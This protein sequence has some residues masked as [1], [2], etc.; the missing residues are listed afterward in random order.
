MKEGISLKRKYP[1]VTPDSLRRFLHTNKAFYDLHVKKNMGYTDT[2]GSVYNGTVNNFG[3]E[4]LLESRKLL[5]N[6]PNIDKIN[7]SSKFQYYF[8]IKYAGDVSTYEQQNMMICTL[9]ENVFINNHTWQLKFSWQSRPI[10]ELGDTINIGIVHALSKSD[11]IIVK[12]KFYQTTEDVILIKDGV[13]IQLPFSQNGNNTYFIHASNAGKEYVEL[14]PDPNN[15]ANCIGCITAELTNEEW[16]NQPMFYICNDALNTVTYA[17]I[18]ATAYDGFPLLRY[19]ANGHDNSF[20]FPGMEPG[21]NSSIGNLPEELNGNWFIELIPAPGYSFIIPSNASDRQNDYCVIS[22]V[23]YYQAATYDGTPNASYEYTLPSE[24]VHHFPNNNIVGYMHEGKMYTTHSYSTEIKPDNSHIYLDLEEDKYYTWNGSIYKENFFGGIQYYVDG[25]EVVHAYAAFDNYKNNYGPDENNKWTVTGLMRIEY[26]TIKMYNYEHL[27]VNAVSGIHINSTSMHSDNGIIQKNG[28]THNMSEFDGLPSYFSNFY[29]NRN[30]CISRSIIYSIRDDLN[31]ENQ[32]V[33]DKPTAALIVDSGYPITQVKYI[34][35]MES[36]I[37][38]ADPYTYEGDGEYESTTNYLSDIAYVTDQEFADVN[39]TGEN[40]KYRFVYHGDYFFSTDVIEFDPSMNYGRVYYI[41]NDPSEFR[42]NSDGH[43]PGRT[44]ARICDIPTSFT[45]LSHITNYAPTY[46]VDVLYNRTQASYTTND[47][48]KVWNEY[49]PKW[50]CH[51]DGVIFPRMY[52]A[53]EMSRDHLY[54]GNMHHIYENPDPYITIP[55][56]T[57]EVNVNNG[58]SGYSVGDTF[59]FQVGGQTVTGTVETVNSGQAL[60]ISIDGTYDI[61]CSFLSNLTTFNASTIGGT[62]TGLTVDVV[63]PDY[64]SFVRY[65]GGY[66]EDMCALKFDVIDNIWIYKVTQSSLD[67]EYKLTGVNCPDNPYVGYN[68][69]F[70]EL[71]DAFVDDILKKDMFVPDQYL[72]KYRDDTMLIPVSSS[73]VSISPEILPLDIPIDTDED[74]SSYLTQINQ[75]EQNT[76]FFIYKRTYE[77]YYRAEKFTAYPNPK[78]NN[79]VLPKNHQLNLPTYANISCAFSYIGKDKTQLNMC[80]FNPWKNTISDY[81]NIGAN[82]YNEKT[83]RN[84]PSVIVDS[85]QSSIISEL[86]H[87]SAYVSNGNIYM[88]GNGDYTGWIETLESE[89]ESMTREELLQ[90]IEDKFNNPHAEPLEVE[91]HYDPSNPSFRYTKNDLITYILENSVDDINKI[92][93]VHLIETI[94]T[95]MKSEEYHAT[96]DYQILD[97]IIVDPDA[98]VGEFEHQENKICYVFKFDTLISHFSE[99][100]MLDADG[101]DISDKC[102]IIYDG[103]LWYWNGSTWKNPEREVI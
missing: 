75:N 33:M 15:N 57:R 59:A 6:K 90:Y 68:V 76:M 45:Q 36:D 81:A 71:E 50:I 98:K 64:N 24:Y 74:L 28:V 66:P 82:E 21:T 16:K 1:I 103:Y 96:G 80:I 65:V 67:K 9:K 88:S 56:P 44:L 101:N 69:E 42:S 37:H 48:F 102:L 58:G 34:Y 55:T 73:S 47:Q 85:F 97:G 10:S 8:D 11:G 87:D 91:S 14:I 70:Y 25:D 30:V 61:H 49:V 99:F 93:D 53:Y 26:Q 94:N 54:A 4:I 77:D 29:K 22:K 19:G 78:V 86:V 51:T 35:D 20:V 39:L 2:N 17:P 5:L 60:T 79:V 62:G 89:L 32:S 43:L 13:E 83:V 84:T 3:G 52:G 7:V 63:V 18:S 95:S 12:E 100:R 41:S 38:Y 27:K 72:N 92:D 46:V 31:H 40:V 23:K